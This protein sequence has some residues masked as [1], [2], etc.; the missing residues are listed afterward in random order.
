MLCVTKRNLDAQLAKFL[1]KQRGE[2][3]YSEFAKRIGVGH[4][5]ARRLESGEHHITLK[6]L[7]VILDKLKVKMGEVFP[8]EF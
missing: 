7:E 1:K 8:G 5:T 4:M 2:Q 6:K 3:S